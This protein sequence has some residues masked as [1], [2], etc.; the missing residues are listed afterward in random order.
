MFTNGSDIA[1]LRQLLFGKD[2]DDLLT[3]KAQFETLERYSASVAGIISEALHL[4]MS[5][6]DSI[7]KLLAPTIEYTLTESIQQ[8]PVQF[9]NVLYPVMGPAIRKSIHQSFAEILTNLNQLLEQSLSL[10][11]LRWRFDAWRT[12]QS[13]AHIVM[14]HTLVYQVEQVFLIHR[15]SGL[16]I[17]HLTA[18][19]AIS[20]DPD[21]ISG[22]LT[23][24][25][26]FMAD[27][28]SVNKTDT[29][30]TLSMGELNLLVEHGPNSVLALVVRG[31]IPSELHELMVET[32]ANIHRY[33]GH[34]LTTYQG[35]NIALTGIE[36]LLSVCLKSRHQPQNKRQPWLVYASLGLILALAMVGYLR[37]YQQQQLLK[38]SLAKLQTQTGVVLLSVEA[39][40]KGYQ[41]KG[42]LDPLANSPMQVI[43]PAIQAQLGLQWE[44]QPYLSLDPDIL[45]KRIRQLLM[46]P[47]SVQLHLRQLTLQVSGNASQ[48]WVQKLETRWPFIT[49]LQGLDK[50]QLQIQNPLQARIAQLQQSLLE[51]RHPFALGSMDTTTS[52][53]EIHQAADLI[54]AL[55]TKARE[56]N[57]SVQIYLQ[58]HTDESGTERFNTHLAYQRATEVRQA[59]IAA[60]TPDSLLAVRN[61]EPPQP[62][63]N[64]KRNERS[65]SYEVE[66]Y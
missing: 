46:P 44:F 29:L 18:A 60:G 54:K 22:M 26:D 45:L 59:L 30:N 56:A 38:A 36:T 51:I 58:G 21:M 55:L 14:L 66:L 13:Y 8:N 6:D 39:N 15:H 27:S 4:R 3:L 5:R 64:L 17:H 24:I 49:G 23:A 63:P 25:Q 1:N 50:S 34:A 12:G 65:V 48:D 52:Q 40:A 28:F 31:T 62:T 2:Y 61:K 37:D 42:L 32:S 33:Y 7:S 47:P 19:N 9:A 41:V 11:S 43:D 20:K 10:R 57:Q 35:D 53:A 16:L